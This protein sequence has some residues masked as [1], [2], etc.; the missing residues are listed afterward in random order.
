MGGRS[1]RAGLA[2]SDGGEKD[3]DGRSH[4]ACTPAIRC[5]SAP[6]GAGAC[7]R[8][9][10]ARLGAGNCPGGTRGTRRSLAGFPRRPC[11]FQSPDQR[12]GLVR[13]LSLTGQYSHAGRRFALVALCRTQDRSLDGKMVACFNCSA[14][15]EISWH[16]VKLA[17]AAREPKFAQHRARCRLGKNRSL[18]ILQPMGDCR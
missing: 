2:G 5:R 16:F 12:K 1:E 14:R 15:Q 4:R 17:T 13:T 6:C 3:G 9:G 7:L 8:P 11:R 10:G 18:F